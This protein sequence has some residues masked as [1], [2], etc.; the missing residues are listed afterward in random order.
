MIENRTGSSAKPKANPNC[1]VGLLLK[2]K[3]KRNIKR[4]SFVS[5][6]SLINIPRTFFLLRVLKPLKHVFI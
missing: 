1:R 4:I 6:M 2:K 3:K 5:Y